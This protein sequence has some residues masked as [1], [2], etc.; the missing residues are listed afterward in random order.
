M[1]VTGE[2]RQARARVRHPERV[3]TGAGDRDDPGLVISLDPAGSP[4]PETRAQ[5][6]E[7]VLVELVDHLAHVRLVREEHRR[8]PAD[9]P[10]LPSTNTIPINPA[11]RI[12]GASRV[13]ASANLRR[14]GGGRQGATAG[15]PAGS[16]AP[17]GARPAVCSAAHLSAASEREDGRNAHAHPAREKSFRALVDRHVEGVPDDL[18]VGQQAVAAPSL[19]PCGMPRPVAT[20]GEERCAR[21]AAGSSSA[22]AGVDPPPCRMSLLRAGVPRR[23]CTRSGA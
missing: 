20:G 11:V 22:S 17:D 2:L 21:Q 4:A 16:D 14:Q 13:P 18:V 7:P 10:R 8:D 3:G 9:S 5:R 6:L 19:M 15:R 1:Q 12:R 23:G